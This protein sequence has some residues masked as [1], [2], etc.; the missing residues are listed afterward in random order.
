MAA[1]VNIFADV[2][3]QSMDVDLLDIDVD[4]KIVR[5]RAMMSW[6]LETDIFY[7][8]NEYG[9]HSVQTS[10]SYLLLGRLVTKSLP[11]YL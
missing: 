7:R 5:A 1:I 3:N 8:I 10:S 11:K 6:N 9:T 4:E 2:S